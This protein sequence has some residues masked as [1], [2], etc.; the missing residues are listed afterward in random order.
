MSEELKQ[1]I[2]ICFTVAICGLMMA[3]CSIEVWAK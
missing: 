2:I 1:L 3:S